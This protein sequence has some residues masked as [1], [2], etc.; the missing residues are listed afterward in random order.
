M[1]DP[2]MDGSIARLDEFQ[3]Q[4]IPTSFHYIPIDQY[5]SHYN[6]FYPHE[7]PV[8]NPSP[9]SKQRRGDFQP[10][11]PGFAPPREANCFEW[12][13]PHGSATHPNFRELW[14]GCHNQSQFLVIWFKR[15]SLMM[16]KPDGHLTGFF[17]FPWELKLAA[18]GT[19]VSWLP[20]K[21]WRPKT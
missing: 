10:F 6:P 13:G 19:A 20:L 18:S 16:V 1:I 7:M 5:R 11:A 2:K 4:Y 15:S 3:L 12:H 8:Q 21:K 9:F 17:F 14:P